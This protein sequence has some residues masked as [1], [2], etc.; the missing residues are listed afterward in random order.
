MLHISDNESVRIAL[1]ISDRPI[2]RDPYASLAWRSPVGGVARCG[3][4]QV[5]VR[6]VHRVPRVMHDAQSGVRSAFLRI[7]PG[8]ELRLQ[9]SSYVGWT[10]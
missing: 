7:E 10:S 1:H 4:G 6:Q 2:N 5:Q 3:D 9:T 8:A